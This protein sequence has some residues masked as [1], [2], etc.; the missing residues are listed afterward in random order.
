MTTFLFILKIVFLFIAV[1][2]TLVNIYKVI[3]KESVLAKWM[4]F[5]AIGITGFIVLQ[6]LI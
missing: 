4:V 5:Q 1:F 3:Y 2:F 6:W